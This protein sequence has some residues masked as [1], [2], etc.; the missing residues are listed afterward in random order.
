MQ[1]FRAICKSTRPSRRQHATA[2]SEH[3]IG[4]Q[5]I[6][7]CCRIIKKKLYLLAANRDKHISGMCDG[8]AVVLHFS[9]HRPRRDG[10]KNQFEMFLQLPRVFPKFGQI[11]VLVDLGFIEQMMAFQG[12]GR[13][14]STEGLTCSHLQLALERENSNPR[15]RLSNQFGIPAKCLSLSIID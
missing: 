6:M 15:R 5:H 14:R 3:F 12:R 9:W 2:F 1:I 8:K 11:F 13:I 4:C 7:L 10:A